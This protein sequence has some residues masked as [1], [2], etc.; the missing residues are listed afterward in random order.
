MSKDYAPAALV[1]AG[2]EADKEIPGCTFSGVLG[3]RAHTFGYHRGR[4]VLP[5]SDYSVKL[6]A[7]RRGPACAASALDLSF[8]AT[9]MK[10]VTKRLRDAALD[11]K[12]TAMAVV[13]EFYGTLNGRTVYGLTHTSGD[14]YWSSATS[15]KS[16]LWHIHISFFREFSDD[17]AAI[18]RVIDI[19]KGIKTPV[20]PPVVVKPP[21]AI[22]PGPVHVVKSGDTL[23]AIASQY[24]TTV[25]QIVA[26]N[27][28]RDPNV[29]D[30]DQVLKVGLASSPVKPVVAAPAKFRM[31]TWALGK[32][33]Y[34]SPYLKSTPPVYG[35]IR[36][37]QRKLK[38]I[39][40]NPGPIDGQY[41]KS[42]Y[43]AV[44]AFQ[45]REGLRVDGLIGVNTYNRLRS[46]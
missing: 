26:L 7:D 12:D 23:S 31:P 18:R 14:G 25:G 41:G 32:T 10:V 2:K 17:Y 46:K 43:A 8:T 40:Y 22:Q 27:G 13:R 4:C 37:V 1:R 35:T 28:I 36:N 38:E 42:T 24:N 19:M 6:V 3:D 9:Q 20:K 5:R 11:P 44:R 39:G 29:I 45:K 30:V 16:H 15:D 21:A 33:S 34:F